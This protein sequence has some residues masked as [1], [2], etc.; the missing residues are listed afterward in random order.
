MLYSLWCS[1]SSLLGINNDTGVQ[2]T[3]DIEDTTTH[4]TQVVT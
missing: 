3:R 1:Q 4:D 2:D